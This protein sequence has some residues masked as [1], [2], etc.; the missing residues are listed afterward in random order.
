VT[1]A[2]PLFFRDLS[3]VLIAAVAGG[4]VARLFRQPLIVGFVLAG[5]LI[6]PFTPGPRVSDL[7][8][9]ELFAEI[10]VV[11]LM[12][13]I[14]IEFSLRDLLRVKWV[15]LIGGPLGLAL[16]ILLALA[17][18]TALGWPPLQSA[19][20]GIVTSVASTMV[21]AQLLLDR[22][23]LHSAHGRVMIGIALVEDLA[24]VVMTVL[25]PALGAL[26][27][28]RL[29][30]IGD[31]LL[32][33]AVVLIP[34]VY[35]AAKVVPRV[36]GRVAATQSD[37]LFL[38]VA[39]V[40]GLGTAAVTQAVGLSLALGAFLGGLLISG[41]DY[42]HETLA[43]LLPLRDVFVALFFVTVGALID[44]SGVL[45]NLTLL[46]AI[47]G[48]VVVG[49]L[50]TR[51]L[52]VRL[53]GYPLSL[54]LLTGVGLSQIGEFSF[55][56]VQVAREVGHVGA[57]VYQAVLAASLL[58][59]LVNAVLE[60]N[61]P[62]WIGAL[63]LRRGAPPEPTAPLPSGYVLLCGFGR[64]G[65]AIG[66]ALETFGIPFEVV[67]RDPDVILE[68]RRRRIR[69]LFGDAGNRSVLRHAGAASATLVIVALPQIRPGE[70]AVRTVRALNPTVPLLA[71]AH[72]RSEAETLRQLGA[73][74]V[75][76]PEVE[77]SATLI[78]HA[79]AALGLPK[80]TALDYLERFRGA[81][82]TGQV[83]DAAAAARPLP[84]VHQV[85][86]GRCA[87]ADQSLREARIRERFGVTVVAVSR[88]GGVV[89]N[90]APETILRAGDVVRVFGLQAQI[91]ALIAVADEEGNGSRA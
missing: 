21:L 82:L 66:E 31:A 7:H 9:L 27:P 77:A 16:S 90:P 6:G 43:R 71:R 10:G 44:P 89:F 74:E 23:E 69:C 87:L 8:T 78:R 68:L 30:A 3:Y 41:S 53:F 60:R 49:K 14:G 63:R 54:A 25:L 12:F 88:P 84:V 36:M 48:L 83:D 28:G 80:E 39:L 38:L 18:G 72:A 57:D 29:F 13:S 51:A 45:E 76:Q 35:L 50:A 42:A 26:E 81:M 32:R 65:S 70:R 64:V 79:L 46:G 58:T 67:E 56:L 20:I 19:V 86:L 40:I 4:F 5:I 91:A 55:V 62:D 11:L 73:T 15:A 52:V 61:A 37:E 17:V 33:A 2:D 1:T 47:V 75:I 24:V 59:L 34:F 85:R 22:G